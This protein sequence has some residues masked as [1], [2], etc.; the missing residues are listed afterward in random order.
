MHKLNHGATRTMYY[1]IQKENIIFESVY[2]KSKSISKARSVGK[3]HVSLAEGETKDFQNKN[4]KFLLHVVL[5]LS[6]LY[7]TSHAEK[8]LGVIYFQDFPL[9]QP[10]EATGAGAPPRDGKA[11][12][13]AASGTTCAATVAGEGLAPACHGA[14]LT[15]NPA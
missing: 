4:K 2:P 6:R 9:F 14:P 11:M 10:H 5:K 13:S 12:L 3:N 15:K 8:F 1:H 7:F